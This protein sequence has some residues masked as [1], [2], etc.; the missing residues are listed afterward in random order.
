[1][2]QYDF[3]VCLDH[4]SCLLGVRLRVNFHCFEENFALFG[5]KERA[6]Q[7]KEE[8]EKNGAALT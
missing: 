3:V 1:M 6:S 8:E 4:G 2:I 7:E 5:G